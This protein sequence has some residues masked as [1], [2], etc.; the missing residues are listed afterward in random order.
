MSHVPSFP[1]RRRQLAAAGLSA[2]LISTAL[3]A[4]AA[5]TSPNNASAQAAPKT[6]VQ[7]KAKRKADRIGVLLHTKGTMHGAAREARLL[8]VERWSSYTGATNSFYERLTNTANPDR[9][10][11][12]WS[13]QGVG[14]WGV[15]RLDRPLRERISKKRTSCSGASDP[16]SRGFETEYMNA[17]KAADELSR[18]AAALAAL[19]AGPK[20]RG[21]DTRVAEFAF[22][23]NN[24]GRNNPP[25][26]VIY[27][28]ATGDVVRTGSLG[29]DFWEEFTL[30]ELLPGNAAIA[31][32]PAEIQALC[33]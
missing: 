3:G 16:N 20:V 23:D 19:P 13:S 22:R 17:L 26:Q 2:L 10:H 32:A 12:E 21:L 8:T 28:A 11:E 14:G 24:N 9:S 27:D 15:G 4:P 31:K 7:V 29:E 25:L 6:K 1:T 18:D 33:E 5:A 30:W